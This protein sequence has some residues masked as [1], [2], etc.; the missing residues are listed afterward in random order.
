MSA[1]LRADV[2]TDAELRTWPLPLPAV[3]VHRD[4]G[5]GHFGLVFLG[6]RTADA[7][8]VLV[9]TLPATAPPALRRAFV[10]EARVAFLLCA[11]DAAV[12]SSSS[13]SSSSS[14]TQRA[15]VLQLLGVTAPGTRG[16][17]WRSVWEHTPYGDV[18]SA[19][20]A[21]RDRGDHLADAEALA[22]ATGLARGLAFVHAC[23]VLL[24]H[25]ALPHAELGPGNAAK[26]AHFRAAAVQRYETAF[27]TLRN[28]GALPL[29]WFVPE[30]PLH[31]EAAQRLALD[32]WGLGVALWELEAAS[33]CLDR[34][35]RGPAEVRLAFAFAFGWLC[36]CANSSMP[37]A[38]A[39]CAHVSLLGA[40]RGEPAS[41][42][43]GQ[44]G[45]GRTAAS[46]TAIAV[47]ASERSVVIGF[48]FF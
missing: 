20:R 40:R 34:P 39:F 26:W 12:A 41:G 14:S 24:C 35:Q 28:K 48:F 15:H 2:F 22:L 5:A 42:A 11:P 27:N 9:K 16:A 1:P 29:K 31:G 17:A 6:R 7:A 37:A 30:M 4:L 47:T 43:S 46:T 33:T 32:V 45:N 21:L 8:D 38:T 10:A 23:G 25:V 44:A 36:T 13:S 3:S 19:V 18:H